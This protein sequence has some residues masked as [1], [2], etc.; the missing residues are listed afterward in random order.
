MNEAVTV[1]NP[2]AH[3]PTYLQQRN[4]VTLNVRRYAGHFMYCPQLLSRMYVSGSNCNI[5]LSSQLHAQLC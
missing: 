1:H 3:A 4:I 5:L 2:Q